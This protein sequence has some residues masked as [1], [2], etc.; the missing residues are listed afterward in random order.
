MLRNVR[1]YS[2]L[3]LVCG[4]AI[5]GAS[6]LPALTNAGD[7]SNSFID[8]VAY[9]AAYGQELS[10]CRD[11]ADDVDCQCFASVAGTVLASGQ[12]QARGTRTFDRTQLA[13]SQAQDSC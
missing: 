1:V 3:L 4:A 5:Y 13:R 6:H 11:N 2:S 12:P 10:Y 7:N 8:P 9:Q